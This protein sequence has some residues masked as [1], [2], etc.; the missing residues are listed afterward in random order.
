MLDEV[1][2]EIGKM[3]GFPQMEPKREQFEK[4]LPGLSYMLGLTTACSYQDI[5]LMMYTRPL[6]KWKKIKI[7]WFL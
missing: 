7:K 2:N 1:I 4:I 3:I 6:R 5:N